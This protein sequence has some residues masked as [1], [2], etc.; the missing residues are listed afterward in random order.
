MLLLD[1]L[2]GFKGGEVALWVFVAYLAGDGVKAAEFAVG[3]CADAEVVAE[4][5]VVEVVAAL[6]AFAREGG[7]FVVLVS[8]L[9]ELV[10]DH[11]LHVGRLVFV[12]QLGRI[13][14]KESV[15]L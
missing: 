3:A 6:L 9:G 11:L 13:A 1:E 15:G 10:F 7:G 4:A 2:T 14:V 5:P 12:W 8:G